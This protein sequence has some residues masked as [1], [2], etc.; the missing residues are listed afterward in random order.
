MKIGRMKHLI[1][2]AAIYMS[3]RLSSPDALRVGRRV[4]SLHEVKEP[5]LLREKIQWLQ[6]HF[7]LVSLQ[8]LLEGPVRTKPQ[9][10]I[11]FDDG[12]Q[13][14][15]DSALPILEQYQVPA[16]FFVCSGFVG[17]NREPAR[18]FC[19]SNLNRTQIL[20][21]LSKQQLIDISQCPLFEIGSHTK[22]HVNLGNILNEGIYEKEIEEDRLQLEDWTGAQV[23]WFAYP[24][25]RMKNYNSA[26]KEYLRKTSF[27]AAFTIVP[28]FIEP[29]GDLCS[30]GRDSLDM[31][32]ST[33]LWGAW[34]RG[35]YDELYRGKEKLNFFH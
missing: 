3:D 17:L 28:G 16:V 24:F 7:E 5:A 1:R 12:Y 10:A 9:V 27:Q 21:P 2:D 34:L 14:A 31:T 18:E 6:E 29:Q 4:I 20:P 19:R 25:G 15:Y 35:S 22:N 23:R 26:V 13:S 8:Q 32:A 30:L 33:R 11:T